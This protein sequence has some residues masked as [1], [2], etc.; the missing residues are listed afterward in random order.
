MSYHPV[1]EL[2]DRRDFFDLSVERRKRAKPAPAT[3]PCEGYRV[4][5]LK[6]PDNWAFQI[7]LDDTGEEWHSERPYA[8]EDDAWSEALLAVRQVRRERRQGQTG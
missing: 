1:R 6:H 4:T 5:M 7:A 8:T 3:P 2:Y